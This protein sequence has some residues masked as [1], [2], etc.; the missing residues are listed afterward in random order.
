MRPAQGIQRGSVMNPN[1]DPS[2]P[3]YPSTA[4]A[5]RIPV[6]LM[7]IPRI[8]VLPISY[9]NAPELLRGLSGNSIPQPWQ[10]GLGFRYHVGPGPVQARIAVTT[11]AGS[12]GYREIWDTV[13]VIRGS[14][15]PDELVMIGG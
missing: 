14:D 10:G 8:P 3:G 15:Y 7:E 13:G 9:G 2:T 1:G 6:A 4:N 11:D 12:N 5:R